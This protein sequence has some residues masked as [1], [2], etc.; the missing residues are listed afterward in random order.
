MEG[1]SAKLGS[2]Q[3]SRSISLPSRL[4]PNSQKIEAQLNK[5]KTNWDFSFSLRE[6]PIGSDTIQTGLTDLAELYSSTKELIQSPLTQQALLQNHSRKM[7]E[8]TLDRSIGLLDACV[9]ARD[10]LLGMKE[11]VQSLQSAIRR[12]VVGDSSIESNVRAYMSFRKNAKKELAKSLRALKTMQNN[13]PPI[14]FVREDNTLQVVTKVLRELSTIAISIFSSLFVFLSVP[15]IKSKANGWSLISKLV[16]L[17]FAASDRGHK[18]F[19]EVGSVDIS[20]CSLQG[21]L[22]KN[23][24]KIDMEMVRTRLQ[25]LDGCID[26]LEAGLDCLFRCLIQHRVS[27][28]NLLTP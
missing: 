5:L 28:L 26:G 27:L 2:H 11:N 1:S 16:P 8:E 25:T 4:H 19:N 20:L 3:P 24:A 21:Q 18:I 17:T 10:L 7:V 14:H 22:R 15:L 6:T 13:L 12:R 23:D 9:A